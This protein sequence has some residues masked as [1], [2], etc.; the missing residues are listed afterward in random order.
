MI[1]RAKEKDLP[2]IAELLKQILM[3]HHEVRPD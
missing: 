2:D 3:L 1:R